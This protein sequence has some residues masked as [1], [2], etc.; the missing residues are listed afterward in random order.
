MNSEQHA[1]L[2]EIVSTKIG[3]KFKCPIC[4]DTTHSL[5]VGVPVEMREFNEGLSLGG[6]TIVPFVP[7]TCSGCSYSIL[8]SA[9]TLG[10]LDSRGKY[11]F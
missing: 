6:A 8:L 7:L 10:I 4:P 1:R 3:G 9:M 2:T 5:L 11:L